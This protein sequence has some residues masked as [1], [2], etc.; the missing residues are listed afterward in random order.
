MQRS[1]V[2]FKVRKDLGGSGAKF[3]T[4]VQEVIRSSLGGSLN[5]GL[6]VSCPIGMCKML[7]LDLNMFIKVRSYYKT[8]SQHYYKGY[9]NSNFR[10]I[11]E[12]VSKGKYYSTIHFFVFLLP[13]KELEVG[14]E[15]K[16]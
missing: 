10:L 8:K 4:L 16:I 9:L 7:N 11:I 1:R 6:A 2:K 3:L 5:A 13:M 12:I 15:K 14:N